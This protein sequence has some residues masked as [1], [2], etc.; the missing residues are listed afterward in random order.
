MNRELLSAWHFRH[1]LDF[2]AGRSVDLKAKIFDPPLSWICF[3]DPEWHD[4]QLASLIA[5]WGLSK[6]PLTMSS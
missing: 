5:A 4:V 1:V 2:C 6:K 3:S